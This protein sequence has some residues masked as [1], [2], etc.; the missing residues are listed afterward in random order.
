MV[1]GFCG[2]TK[3]GKSTLAN[4]TTKKYG[5]VEIAFATPLK[6]CCMHA[7]GFTHKQ[8]F[9]NKKDTVDNYWGVTPREILQF[10]GTEVFRQN[11]GEKQD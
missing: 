1:I 4:Y 9:G 2:Q 11:F 6:L 10:V 5:F 8:L 7:F 3:H